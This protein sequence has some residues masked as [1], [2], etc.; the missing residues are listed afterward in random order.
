VKSNRLDAQDNLLMWMRLVNKRIARMERKGRV[1]LL[2]GT[3]EVSALN[4]ELTVRTFAE[5]PEMQSGGSVYVLDQ[6]TV[7]AQ[8]PVTRAWQAVP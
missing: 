5:I 8:N 2:P 3:Q 6:D 4:G 1:D 7:Y